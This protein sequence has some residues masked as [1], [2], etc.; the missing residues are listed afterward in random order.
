MAK[1]TKVLFAIRAN[2]NRFAG[3]IFRRQF[4]G[5]LL[6]FGFAMALNSAVNAQEEGR[7]GAKPVQ[8]LAKFTVSVIPET[9]KT[10]EPS[11]ALELIDGRR[12]MRLGREESG[13]NV[14]LPVGAYI[15]L[16]FPADERLKGYVVTPPAILQS[17]EGLFHFPRNVIGMLHAVNVG[18]ATITVKEL[19]SKTARSRVE[20]A[21][22]STGPNWS[23]YAITAGAPFS[24]V[25]GRW[26]VPAVTGDGGLESATWV[27]I[28]GFTSPTVIQTGTEQDWSCGLFSCGGQYYAWY[29]LFPASPVQIGHSVSPGDSMFAWINF[30]GG[31]FAPGSPM[32]WAISIEDETA[33][34]T[35]STTASYKGVLSSAEWIEEAPTYCDPFGCAI[36]P[37]ADYGSVTFDVGDIV[38]PPGNPGFTPADTLAIAQIFPATTGPSL[39]STPSNPD[40]DGDGF[41][42]A[43]GSSAPPPPGPFIT[44]TGL[45]DAVLNQPYQQSLQTSGDSSPWFQLVA[46][47]LPAGLTFDGPTGKISGTPA[48]TGSFSFSVFAGDANN[49]GA[50]SQTQPLNLNVLQTPPPPDFQLSISPSAIAMQGLGDCIGSAIV[51]I[52]RLN[53]FTQP[54]ALSAS[55]LPAGVTASFNPASAHAIQSLLKLASLPCPATIGTTFHVT[56]TAGNLVRE[57][58]VPLTVIPLHCTG[59][60]CPCLTKVN[61]KNP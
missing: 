46:G 27:G 14:E 5:S 8:E 56:G 38:N 35:Y 26:K 4:F 24:Y 13:R 58:S 48:A 21:A 55:G 53:G 49:P 2:I 50:F 17:P 19:A 16:N 42:V 34:W 59:A 47:S 18:T 23:G 22:A 10:T 20:N 3:G 11:P 36:Q 33:G 32:T 28:D 41:T 29:E 25:S 54:V 61:C 1:K 9:A 37:L 60:G 57:I 39:F 15:I 31:P 7:A 30:A 40:A 45:L 51:T 12:Y 52:A 6:L 43:F 44:T